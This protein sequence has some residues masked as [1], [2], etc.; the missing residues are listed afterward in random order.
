VDAVLLDDIHFQIDVARLLGDLQLAPGDPDAERVALLAEQATA[1]ARPKGLY[2]VAYVDSRGD[3]TTVIDGVTFTSRVLTVN[4]VNAHRVFP[5]VATCGVEL[6]E[7][8][9]GLGDM[10]E[11]YWA[12]TIKQMALRSATRFLNDHL[13]EHYRPGKTAV[14]NPGSLEDWP[15]KEQRQLFA[16]LHD[17][18]ASIGVELTDSFL[19]LP[20]KSVS[21]IRFPTEVTFENCQLCPRDVCPGRTA[22]YDES[23][24][25]SR[26]GR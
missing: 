10:F 1:L 6:E 25:R 7:W 15:I 3:S 11:R 26:Y 20:T 17:P 14:M 19:M 4:M 18:T 8:S 22:P 9:S 23:L 13:E 2:K 24:F 5:F 12:D 21:G 16:L